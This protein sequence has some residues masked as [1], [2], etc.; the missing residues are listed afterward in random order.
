[1]GFI[2]DDILLAPAKFVTWIGQ[3]LYDEAEAEVTDESGLR[4]RLLELQ[5]GLELEQITE[6]D[7]LRQ[8]S[9]LMR[10]INEIHKYKE[11]RRGA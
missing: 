1:M 8:E 9:A 4:E 7:Y 10:R 11:A 5:T 3:T 2:L 6:E